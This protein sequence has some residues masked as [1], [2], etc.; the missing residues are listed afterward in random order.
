LSQPIS[1]DL[2]NPVFQRNLFELEKTEALAI[3]ATF[4]KLS[5]LDWNEL[6]KDKGLHWEL[7]QSR[8]GPQGQRIYSL[9]IT[10]KSRAVAYR[11]GNYLRLLSLH[12]D[13]DSTYRS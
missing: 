11:D 4:R 5:Q 2:N 12:S 3:L 7:I 13:H 1:L 6:Y 10:K 8:L 9:R